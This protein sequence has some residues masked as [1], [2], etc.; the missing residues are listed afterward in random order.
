VPERPPSTRPTQGSPWSIVLAG[1]TGLIFFIGFIFLAAPLG[2]IVL[3][4]GVIV[5]GVF[6][7]AFLHYL[8]WGRW[9]SQSIREEVEA[10]ERDEESRRHGEDE[11]RLDL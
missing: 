4:V 6:V 11:N 8:L 5:G 10:E 9:L 7:V 2:G 1:V 3:G